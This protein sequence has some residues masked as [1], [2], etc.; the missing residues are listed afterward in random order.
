MIPSMTS[1][2]PMA[3]KTFLLLSCLTI[4]FPISSLSSKLNLWPQPTSISWPTP[5]A[6]PL[7]P[8]FT[9]TPNFSSHIYL[10][11]AITRYT[12]LIL[13]ERH[14]PIIPPVVNLSSSSLSTL[15]LSISD[16]SAPL[17]PGVDES[18]HLYISTS[19]ASLTAVTPWGA[20]RGLET[21]SQLVWGHQPVVPIGMRIFDKPLFTHRGL[22]LDTSRNF[23]SVRSILRTIRAMSYNK[24]NVFHWHITDSQSF[25][26]V[27][28]SEPELAAKG[29]YG[30]SMSYSTR[31]VKRIIQYGLSHGVRVVPEID[32]PGHTASWAEAYPDIV[33]CAN[34]FWAPTGK[35]ALAAEPG[36]GE[37]NPLHAKT[38]QVVQNVLRDL[39]T[40]F[41][42]QYLHAGAD[43]VNTACWETDPAVARFISAGGTH[44]QLLEKFINMTH[45]YIA[46]TLNRTA[47]YWEDVLLGPYVKVQPASLPTESTILQT[48]NNRA[49]N[50]KQIVQAGYRVIVSSS[51]FYYLD[52]GHGGWVG[53]DSR[54]DVQEAEPSN[55]LFNDPG[56]NGGSWCAPYKSWQRVYDYDILHNLTK[57]EAKRVVG[58][59]V[60]LWSEQA[61]ETVLDAKLWPRTSAAAE[62]L[63]SG[64]KDS[65]GRKRYSEATDRLN[66]WRYRLVRRGIQAEPI[67][68]LWCVLHP[69]MCNLEQ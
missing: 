19:G 21:F 59:E 40:L 63:W 43:E 53:N 45:P 61:D 7:S 34:R 28:P 2:F 31:D 60:A 20:M 3:S 39:S 56:G 17:Q 1:S 9:I 27:L 62:V 66:E 54:Y 8:S 44:D 41:L 35:P 5:A 29:S 10:H 12:R 65:E 22:L 36:T 6:I 14:R 38:Y 33:T 57:E 18:Y 69:G 46:D 48:W 13:S 42:D 25:P 30:S 64:N 16:L 51:D 58:G 24:M 4:L 52:C 26:I 55:E 37:L 50:T 23:Y 11:R 49:K 47:V 15:Y 67:Q 32:M 68:P